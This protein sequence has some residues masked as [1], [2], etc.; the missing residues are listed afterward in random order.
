MK[1]LVQARYGVGIIAFSV[2]L[3]FLLALAAQILISSLIQSLAPSLLQNASLSWLIGTLP[4]YCIG[5]PLSLIP[6]RLLPAQNHAPKKSIS[7]RVWICIFSACLVCT[8]LL[9]FVGDAINTLFSA[10][11]G[12]PPVNQLASM[13]VQSPLWFNLLFLVVLAPIMEEIFL[14]KL[15]IDRLLP[16]GELA[17]V[18]LS[19]MAFGLVHGNFNQLFYA[20]A[21][22]ILFGWVYVKTRNLALNVSLHAAL[23]LLGGVWMAEIEKLR[24]GSDWGGMLRDPGMVANVLSLI[25][26]AILITCTVI[27]VIL[28]IWHRKWTAAARLEAR[29][30]GFS[31]REWASMLC[32]SPLVWFFLAFCGLMFLM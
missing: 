7:P 23:N 8:Y 16:Y 11:L 24:L 29:E 27:C 28:L 19:G 5:M 4:L 32:K 30:D 17:A 14:R 13:T 10:L 1:R 15:L 12:I 9:S 25:Y 3:M 20:C 18:L 26:F 31:C 6:L 21:S 2:A 22:G